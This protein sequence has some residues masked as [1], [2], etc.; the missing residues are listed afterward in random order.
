MKNEIK[1][2]KSGETTIYKRNTE[3]YQLQMI[4]DTYK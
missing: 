4:V 2:S 3:G 1:I